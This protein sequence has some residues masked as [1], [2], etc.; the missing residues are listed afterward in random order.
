VAATRPETLT[1]TYPG[2]ASATI[3]FDELPATLR[4]EILRQ[5][6]AATNSSDPAAE[7][8][9]LLEWEDGWKEVVQVEAGCTGILRYYVISRTEEVGRLSLEHESGYPVVLE[10]ERRPAGLNRVTFGET[11]TLSPERSAREGKKTDTWYSLA[12]SGDATAE[13]KEA[14]SAAGGCVAA[15]DVVAGRRQQ[16]LVDFLATLAD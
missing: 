15:V 13:L 9:V 14:L 10:V 8:Y 7:S 11:F 6:F 4:S 5:P 12:Q 16:D 1:I 2:G 3:R